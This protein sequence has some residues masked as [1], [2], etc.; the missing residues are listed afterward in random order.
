MI[1]VT[2]DGVASKPGQLTLRQAVN[3]A[4]N[5]PSADTIRFDSSVFGTTPQTITL[6]VGEL[7]LT[8][9]ALTTIVGPG[10]NLL[11]LN[12]GGTSRVFH[13][14]GGSAALS[15]LTITGGNGFFGGALY[16]SGGTLSLTGCTVSGNAARY[17]GGLCNYGGTLTLSDCTVTGNSASF[18][19]GLS[20]RNGATSL[21]DCT[22][23]GN[24]AGV[25]GGGLY[26]HDGSLALYD[27]NLSGNNSRSNAGGVGSDA[28][29]T[30]TMTNVTISGNTAY[31]GGGVILDG[32]AQSA[33]ALIN[34][35]VNGNSAVYDGGISAFLGFSMTNTIVSGNSA[36]VAN[37]DLNVSGYT[38]SNNI[39]GSDPLLA[40]LGD[41]GGPT[42]T[43]PL[44]PGSP[45]IGAGTSAGAPGK[46]QRGQPRIRARRHRRLPEPGLH[47]HAG[48]RQH[49]AVGRRHACI[50][51]SAGRHGHGEEC[52]RAGE[53][54]RRDLHVEF[55]HR[56]LCHALG[57]HGGH[58]VWAGRGDGH[59]QLHAWQLH[60]ERI[61]RRG[62]DRQLRPE[63]Y[64]ESQPASHDPFRRG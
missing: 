6:T 57:G 5:L 38:G 55:R 21:T 64:R 56:R 26:L 28:Y 47:T 42:P 12:G 18:G 11:T 48:R 51:E 19:G 33:S 14:K 17:G 34:C 30:L 53:W 1:N 44:L 63:Q 3:L 8:D 13:D 45:A 20:N 32:L 60:R 7:A 25:G 43:I 27:V 9:S 29:G 46:D 50:R 61:G 62:R 36:G 22:V 35:T 40:P 10:A 31:T 54:R 59:G 37:P 41:Y 58:R 2:A 16:N 52:R 4:N 15:G 39:I 24:S 23:S 49:P